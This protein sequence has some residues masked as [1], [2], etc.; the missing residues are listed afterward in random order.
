MKRTTRT[1]KTTSPIVER[2]ATS[3]PQLGPISD[4][5]RSSAVTPV[6]VDDD[7][8]DLGA[9]VLGERLGLHQDRVAA[10]RGHHRRRRIVDAGPGYRRA[11]LVSGV[12]VGLTGRQR[13]FVLGAAG[14]LDAVVQAL[15]EETGQRHQHDD[16]RDGVPEPAS[17]DEVDRLLAVVEVVAKTRE[18]AHQAFPPTGSCSMPRLSALRPE[19]LCPVLKNLSLPRSETIGCVNQKKTTRSISVGEAQ[20]EREALHHAGG[21]DVEHHR[22]QQR[23][24]V[25]GQTGVAGTRPA[26][27]HGHPHRLAVSH[28]VPDA[29]EV[30]DEGVRRDADGH[31]QAGDPRQGQ[32][33]PGCLTQEQHH[34]VRRRRPRPP[35]TR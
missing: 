31:D 6:G 33:E 34:G 2:S 11:Q 5:E 26:A 35:G 19:S 25:G 16:R 22:G 28:L 12:L 8:D 27:L 1:R 10:G 21:E 7:L 20:T 13:H 17:A 24:R 30:D 29:F 3:A 18:L 32:R 9:L 23:D 14:E 4:W 15:V